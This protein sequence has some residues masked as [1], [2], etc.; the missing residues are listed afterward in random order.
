MAT[1]PRR[2]G[3]SRTV[4]VKMSAWALDIMKLVLSTSH[5]NLG[6]GLWVSFDF[7]CFKTNRNVS[8]K[9]LFSQKFAFNK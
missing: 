9:K 2:H 6:V 7:E 8:E 1:A 4:V 5:L 3:F